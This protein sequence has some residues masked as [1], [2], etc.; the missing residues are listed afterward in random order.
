[1]R[2]SALA[3]SIAIAGAGALALPGPAFARFRGNL[4]SVV[5]AGELAAA[6]IS[7]RCTSSKIGRHTSHTP[8]GA[9]KTQGFTAHWGTMSLERTHALFITVTKLGGSAAAVGAARSKL[10]NQ[11]LGEGAPIGV[12]FRSEWHGS[13]GSCENP[14]TDDCTTTQITA[15]AKSSLIVMTLLDYPTSGSAAQGEDDPE[16]LAQEEADKPAAVAIA[17]AIAKA[18]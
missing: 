13:T 16:D 5:T 6:H 7:G 17:K 3:V 2:R 11:I 15:F 12:G 18:L 14:P 8:L 9:L 10:G 4:C 1:M